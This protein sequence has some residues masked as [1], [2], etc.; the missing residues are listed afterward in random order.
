MNITKLQL[1]ERGALLALGSAILSGSIYAAPNSGTSDSLSMT[2]K[3]L[4]AV[5]IAPAGT[6]D[7]LHEALTSG[8]FFG[9]VRYRFESV[10]QTRVGAEFD[11]EGRASTLRTRLGYETGKFHGM[12]GVLEFSNVASVPGGYHDYNDAVSATPPNRP[13][14]A[15]PTVTV[16]N[17]VYVQHDNVLN[18]KV[19][20]GRQRIALGNKRFI[21]NVGWR[22]TEQTYDSISYD[23]KYKYGMSMY[24]AY[25]DRANTILGASQEH[26]SHILNLGKNWENLGTLT[27]YGYYLDFPDGDMVGPSGA[28]ST[29]T[30]GGNFVGDMNLGEN[31]SLLYGI[32]L[33]HQSDVGDNPVEVSATYSHAYLGAEVSG[34][35]A[36]VGFESLDG[37][38]SGDGNRAFQT[39]LATKHAWNGWA[40][41]FLTTPS[42]GLED[43]YIMVGF[44]R[45]AFGADV[46]FHNFDAELS[47]TGSY[48]SEVDGR[49]SYKVNENMDLGV[50]MADFNA[51]SDN[52]IGLQDTKKYWIWMSYSW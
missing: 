18:G 28:K 45:D 20:L 43:V 10:D 26:G 42:G 49:I 27:A 40:D 35:T 9:S 38:K 5:P 7:T 14:I 13:T 24:Y 48:G 15:D 1:A 21:G 16:V 50:K 11:S 12:S 52:T 44:K 47:Q 29:V 22:Q 17:Q 31:R 30:I 6:L 34:I 32:E 39:P 41:K 46:T 2:E 36:K 3:T 8:H 25:I 51:D 33:A 19:K 37:H 4:A 23:G